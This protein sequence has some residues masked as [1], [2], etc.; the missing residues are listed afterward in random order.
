MKQISNALLEKIDRL[1]LLKPALEISHFGELN[2]VSTFKQRP[3]GLMCNDACAGVDVDPELAITK[4]LVE[5]YERAVFQEGILNRH[6]ACDRLHSDG[7]AAFPIHIE[8]ALAQ[9]RDNAY[10]EAVERYVWAHWWDDSDIGHKAHQIED[11][12]TGYL[13]SNGN[14]LK[15]FTSFCDVEEFFVIE[16]FVKDLTLN[17]QVLIAKISNFGFVSGGAAG[18][19]GEESKTFGR[20]LSELIRHGIALKRGIAQNFPAS[21]FYEKR[22]MYF[23]LGHGNDLV[24]ERLGKSGTNKVDLPN[25]Q[26]DQE[27]PS[28]E[29]NKL[30]YVHRCL[31][32]NQPPFVDGE[33][34][35]LCL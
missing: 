5:F 15:E 17:V 9:A 24:L 13:A 3:K 1:A 11:L 23:G 30:I 25:L 18:W 6:P 27:I 33:L 12:A 20:G 35:R 29:F 21:T 8:N 16:P 14:S 22:L 19:K 2:F 31:F 34:E 10:L 26:I 7:I 32:E 28:R 4:A